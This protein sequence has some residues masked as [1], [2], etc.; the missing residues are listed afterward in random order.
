MGV[1]YIGYILIAIVILVLVVKLLAW[2][3]K[4]LFKL[5]GNGILGAILLVV[6]NLIGKGFGF[7]IAINLWTALIAGFFGIPGVIVMVL[8]KM[9][10]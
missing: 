1:Q 8:F 2:P 3:L 9:F 4:L 7:Y 5:V 6:V 10:F